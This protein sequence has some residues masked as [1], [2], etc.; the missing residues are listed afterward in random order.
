MNLEPSFVVVFLIL[1]A[2]FA[3]RTALVTGVVARFITDNRR[4]AARRIFRLPYPDEQLRAELKATVGIVLFDALVATVLFRWQ[5]LQLS[6]SGWAAHLLT[7]AL[8]FVWFEL[9]F[10]LTHRLLHTKALYFIH[11]QHHLAKVTHPLTA[12]SFSLLERAIL[13][14]GVVGFLLALQHLLPL[15]R[16]GAALYLGANYL[17]NVLGH[18]NTELTPRSMRR[19]WFGRVWVTPTFHALH[20]ARYG[21]HYGLFTQVLDRWFGSA[22]ADYERVLDRVEEGAGLARLTERV[23]DPGD[24]GRPTGPENRLRDPQSAQ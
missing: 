12:M 8:L 10:Y 20:H 5:I 14:L 2:A 4:L 3:L 23:L 24:T 13:Q 18:S 15:S 9:W 6:G 16:A 11:E 7:F 22:F 19:G 1:A 21:G 17:F